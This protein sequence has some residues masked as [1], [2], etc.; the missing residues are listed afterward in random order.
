MYNSNKLL[1]KLP[2]SHEKFFVAFILEQVTSLA[3]DPIRFKLIR[4]LSHSVFHSFQC[5][6]FKKFLN[7]QYR[8]RK[9]HSFISTKKL[10]R[11]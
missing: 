3:V 9:V 6:C 4:S 7:F 1:L 2:H 8:A 11:F 10:R 5:Q